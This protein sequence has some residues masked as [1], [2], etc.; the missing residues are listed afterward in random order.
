MLLNTC[1][2]D[3]CAMCWRW[4]MVH[5]LRWSQ[6]WGWE[7][8]IN[9][10]VK[11]HNEKQVFLFVCFL[12]PFPMESF[13]AFPFPA[14]GPGRLIPGVIPLPAASKLSSANGVT[15]RRSETRQSPSHPLPAS[16]S[17]CV[18]QGCSS[19][20][21]LLPCSSNSHWFPRNTASSF[22]GGRSFPPGF[23]CLF[24]YFHF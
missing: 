3:H 15:S 11:L 13:S 19:F 6:S 24:V 14:L 8:Y 18:L 2:V 12:L 21:S 20:H 17:G 22:L 23:I 4:I 7:K 5:K 9:R 1:C 10:Y 16:S